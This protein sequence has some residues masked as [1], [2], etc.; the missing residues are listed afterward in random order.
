MK[1]YTIGAAALCLASPAAAFEYPLQFTPLSGAQGLVV[2]G[3]TFDG[4]NVVGNCSYHITRSSG[5]RGGHTITTYF[6][7]TCTWDRGGTLVSE[8]SGAPNL[9]NP[10]STVGGVTT[11]AIDTNGEYTGYDANRNVG[12]INRL[13]P[14]YV[15]NTASGGFL[16]LQKQKPVSI[17]LSVQSVGDYPLQVSG[18]TTA[19]GAIIKMTSNGCVN[20][21]VGG[22]CAVVLQYDPTNIVKGD[23][24]YTYYDHISVSL[25]SNSG[26]AYTFTE[27]VETPIK[28]GGGA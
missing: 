4:P 2:A 6:N 25:T 14:Q 3:Y 24:P 7:Q 10:L 26:L 11:Y 12:F 18:V 20:V 21:P 27:T 8:V 9:P 28:A 13:S 17:T 22:A 19:S 1:H 23:N 15:F 16:F 5:G